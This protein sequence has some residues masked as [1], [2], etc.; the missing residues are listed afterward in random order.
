M[1]ED[2][3]KGWENDSGFSFVVLFYSFQ[4]FRVLL[5]GVLLFMTIE[6]FLTV[7]NTFK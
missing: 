1:E 3:G 4:G 6:M 2:G 5:Q 7:T